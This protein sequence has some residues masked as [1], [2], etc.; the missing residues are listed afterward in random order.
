MTPGTS[1]A[2][3]ILDD[4]PERA[5]GGSDNG[6]GALAT[7]NVSDGDGSGAGSVPPIRWSYGT[8]AGGLAGSGAADP[9]AGPGGLD[10]DGGGADIDGLR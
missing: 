5:G 9:G 7:L 2:G 1:T 6:I 3:G 10:G 8:S 4:V